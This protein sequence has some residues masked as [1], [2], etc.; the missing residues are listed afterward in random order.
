A[1]LMKKA[2]YA[3]AAFG[4]WHLG[5][6]EVSPVDWNK[7]LKPGPLEV[8]FEYYFGVPVLNS[9]PPVVFVD[10][11]HVVGLD[12]EKDPMIYGETARTRIFDEKFGINEI[13]GGRAA[14]ERYQD[15]MVGTT[16]KDT[17]IAWI[18]KHQDEPFFIYFASTNIH[19]PFTPSPAFIG[20][21]QAGPYGDFIQELDWMVGEIL[22]TLEEEGLK[23]NTLVIFTSDNGAMLNR[24]GQTALEA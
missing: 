14:H 15:R 24:G 5:F 21:S 19:H 4:K 3:T 10:N 13:G 7:P 1:D 9:H 20:S 6:G 12:P 22:R 17:A 8:G 11:H 23:E 18:R 16:L 2:G